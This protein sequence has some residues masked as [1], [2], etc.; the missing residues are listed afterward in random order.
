MTAKELLYEKKLFIFDMDGTIYLGEQPFSFAVSFI[1]KLRSSGRRVLFFTNNASHTLPYYFKKLERLGFSPCKDEIL[2]SGDVTAEFL[3]RHRVCNTVYLVG[4]DELY[5]D[6]AARGVRLSRNGDGADIVVTSFDT[7]LTYEKLSTACRLIRGGAEYLSTHPD[8]NCPTEDGFI[9]DSGAIAAFVTASTGVVPR[10]FGKPYP[11]TVDM[12]KEVT[13]AKTHEICSFGD[14]LYTDIA[15]GRRAGITSVLV[16]TGETKLSDVEAAQEDSR[17]DLI[18]PS[19]A[20][21]D[22]ALFL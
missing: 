2:T 5:D 21:A 12:I 4:T 6:W 11:E 22:E 15:I 18:I 1:N 13:G 17:P 10:Y 3:L 20:Y 14:R 19:L 8:L 9:P 16:L 7:S